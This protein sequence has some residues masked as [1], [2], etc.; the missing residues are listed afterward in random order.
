MPSRTITRARLRCLLAFAL[1]AC[2]LPGQAAARWIDLGGDPVAVTL[3]EQDGPRS[4]VEIRIGGFAAEPVSIA[5]ETWYQIQ[6]DGESRQE[7]AGMPALPDVRRSLLIPGDREMALRIVEAD[8]T[9]LPGLPVAPSKGHLPRSVDPATV[10]YAFG[11]VYD[12]DGAWPAETAVAE[13]PYILRDCRGQLVDANVFQYLP[14]TRTLRV[15]T[16]LL[17]EVAPVGPAKVNALTRPAPARVD[18]QFAKLYSEHFINYREA[19]RY[20][21]VPEDGGIL[22]ICYDAFL[23]GMEPYVDWK[24]QKGIPTELVGLSSIGSTYTQVAAY[25]QDAYDT[26]QPAY[27]LLVGDAAQMPRHTGGSDPC[28]SLVAGGDNYPDLFVGRFSAETLSHVETQVERSVRYERDVPA[29]EIWPQYGMGVASN[30]GPG[31]DG[32]YDNEHMDVI[33]QKLLDY[34]YLAVDQI[35]DP[36]GTAS[37]VSSG[38]NEGRGIV[39]YCGHGSVTSWGSTGFSVSH[40]NALSNDHMLPFVSCVA[41]NNGTFSSG[42]CFG[43]AW[44]RATNGGVPT[45]GIACYASYISQSWNPPMCAQDETIDLLVTDAMRTVGGLYFNGSCQMMDE[46]GSGGVTEF[47]NWTIF[48][49]PSLCV[50]TKQ[51]TALTVTHSGVLLIGMTDYAVDVAGTPDALCALYAGGVLYGAAVTDAA[52]MATIHLA[53]PPDTPM[54]LTL[55]VTAYNAVTE[56]DPVEVLPPSGPYLVYEGVTV[57]DASGD[58]DGVLDAGETDDLEIELENVGVE[59]ATNVT[60]TLTSP[61][62]YVSLSYLAVDYGDIP[63]GGFSAG[64]MP[65]PAIISGAA[66]DGHII[67][68]TVH[69]MGDQGSW[70]ADFSLPVQAPVLGAG[71]LAI[72]DASWG[73]ASG[74][75]DAGETFLLQVV[76]ANT[77]HSDAALLT[78]TLSCMS[79]QVVLHGTAGTCD[80]VTVGGV[81]LMGVFEVEILGTCPEPSLLDFHLAIAGPEGFA[82]SVAFEMPVGGWFDDFE[83]D[84]GW[85]VGM[86]GDGAGSG[87]WERGDPIGTEYSGHVIAPEDDHTPPP[88]VLCYVTGNGGGAAGDDDVDGGKT[89]LLSPVFP[90]GGAT[91][92]QITY[93][94]WY[95]NAWGNDP[96]NDWWDVDVTSDGVNW[97]SLEH[98]MTT[99]ASW[100][101]MTFDLTAHV[102]MTDQVQL[103]F[104]AAD[105]GTGSLVEAGVDDVLLQA[106]YPITTAAE[107]TPA[108]E[109]L[110]LSCFP[111]PF[112]PKTAIRF[113]LPAAGPAELAVYDVRGRRVRTL[114]Q[115]E[116]IAG[117]HEATW[118]GRDDSGR[119][120][121]SGI[122]FARVTAQG[123]SLTRKLTLLK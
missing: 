119:S 79:S 50:R 25:I 35:Y 66:P 10:P 44:L 82:Q 54:T 49:D 14:A 78:G 105:E 123:H 86:P 117:T 48:G 53:S 30:Q 116:L 84:R 38:L 120:L 46:Y 81:G 72:N 109:R 96:D 56:I 115:G 32:E 1:L 98:T 9:D 29:V 90:L 42:T 75:A 43:E 92:A 99:Q 17:V 76:L 114:F 110:A 87:V 62:P 94:R 108:P 121:A 4:L 65:F 93:W 18:R 112:N 2:L 85:T 40:I 57:D 61:D 73:N 77:G 55:T 52:G 91:S 69:A 103:R 47:K 64:D 11:D 113:D 104:V 68:F 20:T 71:R 12:G 36:S 16:R 21:P 24:L 101:Q 83:T 88:G 58:G 122:Y 28:Y 34:G 63:A 23:S 31:D 15:W 111:N 27:V 107:D 5:G 118:N 70:D 59:A 67:P 8:Y 6:L 106:T 39:N 26:W 51:A 45:G 89:T 7:V 3:V 13:A 80:L 100:V 41:C 97:V 102:A 22:V 74:T 60:C 95:S 37:M 19:E 33:R